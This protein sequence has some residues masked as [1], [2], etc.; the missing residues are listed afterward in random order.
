MEF[1]A[2]AICR[3][4]DDAASRRNDDVRFGK[5][6]V[7]WVVNCVLRDRKLIKPCLHVGDI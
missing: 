7:N 5:G 3:S 1:L 2:N 6:V 4:I